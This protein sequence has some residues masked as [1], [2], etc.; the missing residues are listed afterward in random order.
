M[1]VGAFIRLFGKS[2]V[3][4]FRD[5][6]M[7]LA[8]SISYFSMMAV[9]PFCLFLIA[10]FTYLIGHDDEFFRFIAA[11]LVSFFPKAAQS[12]ARELR[13]AFSYKGVGTF[14]FLAYGVLS[15]QLY[16]SLESAINV[17]FKVKDKR[18]FVSHLFIS[19]FIITLLILFLLLSF[20]ASSLILVLN[21]LKDELPGLE[22]HTITAFM[23]KY[24]VPFILVFFTIATLYIVMPKRKIR[25]RNAF[26]GS[27]IASV[28]LEAAK[29][30]FTFYVVKVVKFGSIYGPLSAFIIFLL[31]GFYSSCIFLIGA[32]TV[33]NLEAGRKK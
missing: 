2:I 1:K 3:D 30:I 22:I 32:E 4:F 20:G 33:H 21:T 25:W 26:T 11:K 10:I 15:Y 23:I 24:I 29:H 5:G 31:W 9:L 27:L 28:F 18:S 13:D 6:G 16:S 17:V 8:G 19:L 7:M 12:I 14:T